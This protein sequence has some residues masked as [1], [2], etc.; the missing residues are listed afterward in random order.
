MNERFHPAA[1]DE[2]DDAGRYYAGIN[3]EL[4]AR[5]YREIDG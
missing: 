5:F 4:G 3:P 1:I 2:F